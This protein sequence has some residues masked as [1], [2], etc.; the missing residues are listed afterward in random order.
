MPRVVTVTIGVFVLLAALAAAS[1]GGDDNQQA[2]PPLPSLTFI[3]TAAP[4]SP[5]GATPTQPPIAGPKAC[6]VVGHGTSG[7]I[8]Y[9]YAESLAKAYSLDSTI[10]VARVT[11]VLRPYNE[12]GWGLS[13]YSAEVTDAITGD[14]HTGDT[15]AVW[16][17]GGLSDGQVHEQ[18]EDP[19]IR[20]GCTYLFMIEPYYGFSEVNLPEP[21]GQ[22]WAFPM[23][24]RFNVG[25]DGR[26]AGTADYWYGIH[27]VTDLAGLTVNEAKAL[28]R[29]VASEVTPFPR[30][31]PSP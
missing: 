29:Q 7:L 5:N 25:A 23:P 16:Q 21:W 1:C 26:L 18:P 4:T 28:I 17:N 8:D 31:T 13:V 10:V 12:G 30:A 22:T 20:V 2:T 19:M 6:Q 3:T 15:F 14:L 24:D 27:P 9:A 11:G